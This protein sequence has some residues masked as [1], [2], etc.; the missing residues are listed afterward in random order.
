MVCGFPATGM[1][2][3]P[4]FACPVA[5]LGRVT[6]LQYISG[7]VSR[8][9]LEATAVGPLFVRPH[10]NDPLTR[11]SVLGHQM[12]LS[13]SLSISTVG[14]LAAEVI[15]D[16]WIS[17]TV[18]ILELSGVHDVDPINNEAAGVQHLSTQF[19]NTL[20]GTVDDNLRLLCETGPGHE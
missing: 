3:L 18:P 20:L 15:T 1:S 4:S 10:V 12:V 8:L 11:K 2:R 13:K 16:D 7:D 6:V 14:V 17:H 9:L 5:R 19:W